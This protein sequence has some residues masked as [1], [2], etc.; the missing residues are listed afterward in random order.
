MEAGSCA[1]PP[2]PAGAARHD[3]PQVRLIV[4]I[5]LAGRHSPC[6]AP[7]GCGAAARSMACARRRRRSPARPRGPG[8]GGGERGLAGP[9]RRPRRAVHAR[10][11]RR[12]SPA[13]SPSNTSPKPFIRLLASTPPPRPA[14]LC[15]SR[16]RASGSSRGATRLAACSRGPHPLL[17]ARRCGIGVASSR[18]GVKD[19]GGP[20]RA[21]REHGGAGLCGAGPSAPAR[22]VS[23]SPD[24]TLVTYLKATTIRA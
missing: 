20:G 19:D 14:A 24:G 9:C 21:R 11:T 4:N 2:V 3:R 17:R 1:L 7:S 18:R 15:A 6:R 10:S 5:F 13:S 8:R 12:P 23:P 22:G 16:C